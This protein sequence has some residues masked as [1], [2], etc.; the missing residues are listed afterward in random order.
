MACSLASSGHALVW[1]CVPMRCVQVYG[2]WHSSGDLT[3]IASRC[4]ACWTARIGH[5]S[6]L[7]LTTGMH[8]R[9]CVQCRSPRTVGSTAPG[10]FSGYQSHV[11]SLPRHNTSLDN[12]CA[13]EAALYSHPSTAGAGAG[14]AH[15]EAF[16]LRHTLLAE[17]MAAA[18]RDNAQV[19]PLSDAALAPA[20]CAACKHVPRKTFDPPHGP[21]IMVA[22]KHRCPPVRPSLLLCWASY[23]HCCLGVFP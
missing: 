20:C 12:T 21:T 2:G 23:P 22:A 15:M 14:G 1:P 6:G 8:A 4:T 10:G 16:S 11:S 17:C 3:Y 19:R 9:A 7:F 18:L 5:A 13:L